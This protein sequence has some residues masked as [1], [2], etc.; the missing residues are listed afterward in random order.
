MRRS[1]GTGLI[2]QTENLI[3][4]AGMETIP[5]RGQTECLPPFWNGLTVMGFP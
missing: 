4:S 1:D 3:D 5:E 2:V